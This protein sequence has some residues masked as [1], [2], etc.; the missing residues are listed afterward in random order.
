MSA[1]VLIFSEGRD[2]EQRQSYNVLLP[3]YA[4]ECEAHPPVETE[5]DAYEEAVL[6]FLN[7]DLPPASIRDAINVTQGMLDTILS[8]LAQSGYAER[9]KNIGWVITEAGQRYLK[10]EQTEELVSKNSEHGYMFVSA[11][12]KDILCYFHKGPIDKIQVRQ[13]TPNDHTLRRNGNEQETFTG[14]SVSS[15]QLGRVYAAWRKLDDRLAANDRSEQRKESVEESHIIAE[16]LFADL[17]SYDEVDETPLP[18]RVD[19]LRD[20]CNIEDLGEVKEDRKR[21]IRKLET[22][23]K[24]F[25]IQICLIFDPSKLNGYDTESPFSR[26]GGID[27]PWFLRQIQWM[28]RSEG[29]TLDNTPLREFLDR[30]CVKFGGTAPLKEKDVSVHML[31]VIPRL[32]YHQEMFPALYNIYP[33]LYSLQQRASSI[34]EKESVVTQFCTK[35]LEPLFNMIFKTVP[36]STLRRIRAQIRRDDQAG[37]ANLVCQRIENATGV[38]MAALGWNV[39]MVMTAIRRLERTHGN[40]TLEKAINLLTLYACAPSPNVRRY[41]EAEDLS[42]HLMK[43]GQLND[44]RRSVSHDTNHRFNEHDYNQF[45]Q[46]VYPIAD[47]LLLAIVGG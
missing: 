22:P 26:L 38:S 31:Q 29:I 1:D 13:S 21:Y 16:Q 43:V 30:E 10:N 8:Q 32:K 5:L 28:A 20:G 19:T 15:R 18:E 6:K 35:L 45:M 25:Y 44:I 11:L 33:E 23:H 40:S 27:T 24:R 4:V 42:N 37:D 14:I 46:I 34:L 39:G 12:R 41:I 7:I 9:K 2:D 17:E 47:R 36:E 3:V